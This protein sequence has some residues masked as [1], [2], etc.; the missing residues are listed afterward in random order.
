MEITYNNIDFDE[1]L[2]KNFNRGEKESVII[3][4]LCNDYGFHYKDSEKI[5]SQ[6]PNAKQ[7]YKRWSDGEIS[8]PLSLGGL[9]P[10]P[11]SSKA[12]VN[13]NVWVANIIG[14]TKLK[15]S[16]DSFRPDF[17]GHGL[18]TL[19]GAIKGMPGYFNLNPEDIHKSLEGLVSVH[20]LKIDKNYGVSW[21][22]D[23]KKNIERELVGYGIPTFVYEA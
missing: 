4:N 2:V 16:Q 3:V 11:A 1:A 9:Q 6:Y 13:D 7:E 20:L 12:G 17:F 14:M 22:W 23:V 21:D 18:R 8:Q 10:C 15:T 19:R 5:Y